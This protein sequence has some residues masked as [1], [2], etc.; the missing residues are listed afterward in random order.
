MSALYG[1]GRLYFPDE[2]D[3]E[4]PVAA[5]LPTESTTGIKRR[6]WWDGAWSGN[7]GQTPQC[8]AYSLAHWVNDG[9][10]LHSMFHSRRPGFDLRE[11]YCEAQKID[12]WPGDCSNHQYDGTSVRAG[13]KVLQRW[14]LIQEYRWATTIDEVVRTLLEHGPVV[15]G[16]WWYQGMFYPNVEGIITPSGAR[17]YGHAYLLNGVDLETGLIRIKNSWGPYWGIGGSAYISIEHMDHLL[18][19][20]GEV[21]VPIPVTPER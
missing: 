1:T 20:Y 19:L 7:Q 16:T 4:Y 14:G 3:A 18:K 11:L 8:V 10:A 9:P 6:H 21:C 17:D 2:R 12:P 15:A 13:A 5:V